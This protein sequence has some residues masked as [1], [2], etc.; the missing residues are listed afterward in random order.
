MNGNQ[1]RVQ[2]DHYYLSIKAIILD[3]QHP[4]TGLLPASTAV[5]I[6]GDYTDA[7]V[8]DNVYSI[9]AVWGLALAYRK[10]DGDDGRGFELE[11]SCIKLMRGLLISM[12]KQAHKVEAFKQ[13]QALHDA[14]HAK[15][16]TETGD[17]V[18]GDHAWGHLQIDATSIFLLITAQMIASG[19]NIIWT[20]DE[21][22]FIQ[23]LVFYIE[24]AYRIP[25][26][27][28]WERGA[29]MNQGSAELNASSLGMAKAALE[30]LNGFNLFGARGGQASVIHI[31]PDNIAHAEITLRSMLPR[32]SATKEVDAALL[33]IIG[34]PAFAIQDEALV[35][36][37][38]AEIVGK[39]QGRYGLKRFLR[40]GHQ[41]VLEDEHRLHYEPEEL[42]QF[43]NIESEWPLFYTYLYLDALF[44]NDT[45]EI[46]LYEKLIEA[47]LVERGG[48][49]LL[50]EL[51]YVPAEA[52]EAEKAVPQSQN[53]L[54]NE[55][56]PLVWAQSLYFL[57]CLIRD[58]LLHPAD[59]DPL[60]RRHKSSPPRPVVQ[61]A[62]LAE[63]EALQQELAV[64]GVLT[65]TIEA[66]DPICVLSPEDMMRAFGEVGRNEK[67]GLNGRSSR[68]L[69]S[70]TTSRVFKLK[71]ETAVS[72]SA[73][74]MEQSF[75]LAYDLN[76]LVERFKSELSY[77]HRHW[78]QL[79]RPTVTVLL[80]HS[81]LN[82]DRTAFYELVNEIRTGFVDGV[83]VLSDR[84][85]HLLSTA[86]FE[87]IDNLHGLTFEKMVMESHQ[88]EK[89]YLIPDQL[90]IPLSQD[91]ELAIEFE[92]NT[93][94]LAERLAASENLY[95]Q[96]E[97]LDTLVSRNGLETAV[98]NNG[99]AVPFSQWLEAVYE[100]AG[101]L[102]LWGIVRRAA[103]L[104][105]KVE[106]DLLISVSAI[107]VQQK[108]IQVGRSYSDDS[109]IIRPLPS[110]ELLD[111]IRT[112]ARD[113]VRDKMLTQEIL[114]YLGNLIKAKPELFK[115]LLTIRVSYFILLLTGQLSREQ[116]LTQGEAY[117]Q[118]M[119]LPPSQIQSRLQN[120]L[121]QYQSMGTMALQQEV[122]HV[123]NNERPV[124]WDSDLE[125]EVIETPAEG[126]LMWRQHNGTLYRLNKA[127]YSELWNLFKH[128]TGLIIGNRFERRN[129]LDS[130]II[131]SDMTP[132]E[133]AFILRIEQ[134]LSRIAAP[135]YR[136]LN[137][138]AL[139][140]LTSFFQQN[141]TL[142]LD[143]YLV[144]D[145]V[146]GHAVRIAYIHKFPDREPSY[147]DF[148][149]DAWTNF[150]AL[151]PVESADFLAQALQFLLSFSP[152][153]V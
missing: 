47:V 137:I 13:T 17:P 95:E 109:I 61:I 124:T 5:T 19:F 119:K 111:K 127:F 151:P 21:V 131:L 54:P 75:Y 88:P 67:L 144:T 98:F 16:D 142:Q 138:E 136:Q 33:S 31:I 51:Y 112:Y 53:R 37:T 116:K 76:F 86:T 152:E 27:G 8:R 87:R 11:Q 108:L 92:Q 38:K 1:L 35:A 84:L 101:Q 23:N 57:G 118:L 106:I 39:L 28:I 110:H 46:G 85:S 150:Y 82:D 73:F 2:L 30:A 48:Q 97:L 117:E 81:L 104:L 123:E 113:D 68:A 29:K 133:A 121:E 120:V 115:E 9:L 90:H 63:D 3:K 32:E 74:F 40:D 114:I 64:H 25:D 24:R 134:L 45:A 105:D 146:I 34:F 128:T 58:K 26:Y 10:I 55:N 41:S 140:V 145:V 62:F 143:D 56:V 80:T 4:I 52:I 6:H 49:M 77:I 100:Q 72:L 15:Y 147:N 139:R 107:L 83:Q 130:R 91:A 50:P 125:L 69:K 79:G 70:L 22:N 78:T 66:L 148:K 42:K 60:G 126:W 141:P 89:L 96:I 149:G 93:A 44:A 14:L 129:T 99:E 59:I 132:G 71:G 65:E 18:V 135:E 153:T 36:R 7:W 94:V 122:L 12:M 102:R 43:A 20:L 103:G